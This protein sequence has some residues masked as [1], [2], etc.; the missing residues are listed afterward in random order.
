MTVPRPRI[1]TKYNYRIK[2]I[3]DSIGGKQY[4]AQVKKRFFWC[5]ILCDGS[6]S[7]FFTAV[8]QDSKREALG[9]IKIHNDLKNSPYSTGVTYEYVDYD[10]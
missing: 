2:I 8:I 4:K 1:E 10:F 5:D 6:S 9:R 3:C 7:I